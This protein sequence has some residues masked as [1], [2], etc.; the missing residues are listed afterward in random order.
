LNESIGNDDDALYDPDLE[1]ELTSSLILRYSH[2]PYRMF[3][4]ELG[5]E[6]DQAHMWNVEPNYLEA[7]M[8]AHEHEREEVMKEWRALPAE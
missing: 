4:D 1:A 2:K 3:L 6:S 8:D 7:L 5:L